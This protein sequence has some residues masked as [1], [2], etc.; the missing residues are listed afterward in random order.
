MEWVG[1]LIFG[2]IL[3]GLFLVIIYWINEKRKGHRILDDEPHLSKKDLVKL[4]K[5]QKKADQKR[6]AK[7]EKK[8]R[9]S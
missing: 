4:Y 1:Y 9:K 7:E 2:L 5:I 3:F 8:A 6:K